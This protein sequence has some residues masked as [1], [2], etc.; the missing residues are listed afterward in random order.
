MTCPAFDPRQRLDEYLERVTRGE[1]WMPWQVPDAADPAEGDFRAAVENR[2]EALIA[3][4]IRIR[5][6]RSL[7]AYA[8]DRA[9]HN[10]RQTP[11][12]K[13]WF[14][15]ARA[16]ADHAAAQPPEWVDHMIPALTPTNPYGFTCPHCVYTRSPEAVGVS[17]FDWHQADPD[18]IRCKICGQSYPDARYP[19]EGR[20]SCP[21]RGQTFTYYLNT[22]EREHP[23]DRT[24]RLAYRWMGH[25]IHVSFSGIVREKKIL[26]MLETVRKLG[27]VHQLT[28]ESRYAVR[29]VEILC[30]FA[31]CVGNWLYHDYW[32]T[33]ADCDPLFAT[34]HHTA[35]PLEWKRHACAEAYADLLQTDRPPAG[36][37][38]SRMLQSYWGAGRIHPSA[39]A[40]VLNSLVP[41]YDL[42]HDARDEQG[43]PLWT[44]A[45]RRAV[46][47]DLI[48]EYAIGAEPFLGGAGQIANLSNKSPYVYL[49]F[50]QVGHLLGLADFADVALRGY[51]ALRDQAFIADGFTRESPAYTEMFLKNLIRIPEALDGFRWPAHFP[52]RSG[53]IHEYRANPKLRLMLRTGLEVLRTNGKY[54]PLSDTLVIGA[55]DPAIFE[56]ALH[57]FP[58]LFAGV[59]PTLYRGQ[60]GYRE[61]NI[62]VAL[63]REAQ[64]R[65]LPAA[66]QPGEY[67]VF[68]LR[69]ED[70]ARDALHLP[71]VCFPAWMTALLRH[72]DSLLALPFNPPGGHRHA[73]N[74]ALFYADRGRILLGERGYVGDSALLA[75]GASTQSHNLVVVD[76]AD[77][78]PPHAAA[79]A[80][81]VRQPSLRLMVSAPFAAAVE[82]ESTAYPQC[83]V[84]RRR[85]LLLKGPGGQTVA[86][87][88]FRVLGGS[89]HAFRLSC[90]LATSDAMEGHLEF[91]GVELPPEEPLPQ[92]GGSTARDHVF[93]LRDARS[94]KPPATPWRAIWRESGDAFRVHVLAPVQLV[95]A[96]HG[97]GQETTAQV[98][99]RLR[100]LDLVNTGSDLASTFIVVH[101]PMGAQGRWPVRSAVRLDL[102]ADAGPDAVALRIETEWGTYRIFNDI[103]HSIA[104]DSISFRGTLGVF[105]HQPDGNRRALRCGEQHWEGPVAGLTASAFEP[106]TPRPRPWPRLPADV[107]AWV[108]LG[109]GRH[110]TGYPVRSATPRRIAIDRFPLQPAT[111]FHLPSIR[112]E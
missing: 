52:G 19:E 90:E 61:V 46:E 55:P 87:D 54:V 76:D 12:G 11:W 106:G 71:D 51:E 31:A 89:R 20:L 73:D 82:A 64:D 111:H 32:D 81:A 70:V 8:L 23:E 44:P 102:P 30:R 96:A 45:T 35:L 22:A 80:P 47:R 66:A 38:R 88:R 65:L 104:I 40:W 25:P 98:G 49:P 83:P 67:A 53:R 95:Q 14:E 18:H 16:I 62:S 3:R 105:L 15:A 57:R 6:P 50:A 68:H 93:G 109:D 10:I 107:T 9:R 94:A 21:R 39:D 56:I 110:F 101:E 79:D 75:W 13:T 60:Q 29:A 4:R 63:T 69:D 86:V 2:K 26:F 28:G 17:M 72:G 91:D 43:R 108:R 24:G 42:V 77:Q 27:L 92:F 78:L 41:A 48:L 1:G 59:L 58:D 99:R 34:W 97:P 7:S 103:D 74:L 112:L 100:Y 36:P 85:L 37:L 33:V 5:H 84:Y